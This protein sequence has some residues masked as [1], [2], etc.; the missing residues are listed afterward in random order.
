MA[1]SLNKVM[2]IGNVGRDPEFR[3]GDGK[4]EVAS[5][6]MATS[7]SWKDKT[8]GERKEKVEWHRVVIFNE[9]IVH[10]VKAYVQNGSKLYIEGALQTRK[11]TNNAGQE[12]YT[13]EVVLQG[14]AGRVLLLDGANRNGAGAEDASASPRRVSLAAA[15]ATAMAMH[16]QLDDEIP[17]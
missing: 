3:G 7:E 15:T 11:W 9:N 14:F 6:S 2:L 17:F 5:L 16:A 8:T 10:V 1:G 12:T 13:T 4:P